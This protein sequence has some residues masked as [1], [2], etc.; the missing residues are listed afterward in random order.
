MYGAGADDDK[1]TA[2]RVVVVDYRDDL[3]AGGNDGLL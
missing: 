1:Q 2:M 3:L